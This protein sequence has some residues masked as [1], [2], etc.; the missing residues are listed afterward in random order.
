MKA[1]QISSYGGPEVM[2]FTKDAPKP[3]TGAGDVLVEINAAGVNPFDRKVRQGYARKAG[4]LSFPATL[5][6]DFAGVVAEVG[7]GVTTVKVGDAVYGQA[8]A[9]SG[10][11]SFAEFTPVKVTALAPK[12]QNLDF[13]QAAAVPL[14]AVSAYQALVEAINLQPGQKILIHGGAGGIGTFAIQLAKH[15][16]AYVATTVSSRNLDYVKELG[17]DQVVDYQAQDFTAILKDF[18]AVYDTV[19]GETYAKSFQILKQGGTIVSMVEQPNEALANQH[20]VTPVNQF[21]RVTT[22]RLKKIT[23]LLE[24]GALTVHIDRAFPLSQVAEALE[25]LHSGQ[26]LG[27][28][29]LSVKE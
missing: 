20:G 13:T 6:G 25:Y 12:P 28:V 5:G 16:G 29:V 11:G 10:K 24:N 8:G 3:A 27:K 17:A 18:D 4:E 23:E 7:K 22:E 9:L 2:E 26:H 14:A 21:T 15:S 1:V 19:G